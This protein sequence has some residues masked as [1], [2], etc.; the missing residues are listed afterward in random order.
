MEK[1]GTF[2]EKRTRPRADRQRRVTHPHL[3]KRLRAARKDFGLE[4]LEDV[5]PGQQ[6]VY[7][8]LVRELGENKSLLFQF[9]LLCGPLRN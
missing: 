9:T 1:T 2:G 8:P 7:R 6:L 3:K 5:W 4:P